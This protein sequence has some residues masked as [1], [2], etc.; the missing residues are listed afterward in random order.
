MESATTCV[1]LLAR[2]AAEEREVCAVAA[3]NIAFSLVASEAGET[4]IA[5]A[6]WTAFTFWDDMVQG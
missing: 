4:H 1:L 5:E 6:V 2:T 3:T